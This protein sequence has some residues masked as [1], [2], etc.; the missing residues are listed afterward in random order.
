MHF[1]TMERVRQQ[2]YENFER[3]AGALFNLCD[4]LLSE[5]QARSLA[6]LSLSPYFARKWPSVYEA[7]Q[8]G[9][10]NEEGL[11]SVWASALLEPGAGVIWLGLDS[12]SIGR[13]EAE[14]SADR[15]MIYVPNLP[16]ATKP[17][18]V[19]WS[20][21]TL[22]LLP[23]QPG[24]GVGILDQRRI[25]TASTAIAVG[26]AQVQ[27]LAP[28]LPRRA[29]LLA[30]RW[31]AIAVFARA[32]REAG[33]SGLM[34][35]KRNR[36]LYRRP[37]LRQAGQRGA[38]RKHG[39]LLQGSR[40][41]TLGEADAVWEGTDEQ[42]KPIIVS[43]W[44]HLHFRDAPDVEVS[45]IRIQREGA[46]D[47]KRDPRES[48]F[49]WVGEEIIPLEQVAK[50]YQRRYSQEHGYRFLKQDLLWTRAHV[51]TPEQFE[52]W[53]WLVAC[54]CNQLLLLKQS[55]LAL[56]RPWESQH[57]PLTLR[58]VRRVTPG[59]LAQLGTPAPAPKPRGKASGWPKGKLR[60]KP[61]HFAVVRKPKPE[62]KTPRQ[63]A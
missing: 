16:H 50:T 62:P 20:Y 18:S 38:P 6:E 9:R 37:P 34:R 12:S 23:E 48:W 27:A 1:N 39:D 59:I 53:S 49:V 57:R 54:A 5:S 42:G 4:A 14:C 35:L 28:R 56:R 15:G 61:A 33:V 58:Q 30:D 52:R 8:D 43:C 55:G 11:R 29:I 47:N 17:V 41:Q 44:Q 25:P 36:K 7:L 10:I 3:S 40:P 45:V 22:M 63:R 31:Y 32:C 26:I 60:S 51:R 24:N 19:G 13:P 2:M 46:R 21:S